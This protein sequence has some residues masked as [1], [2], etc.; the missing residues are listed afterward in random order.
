MQ[1]REVKSHDGPIYARVVRLYPEQSYGFIE[2]PGRPNVYFHRAVVEDD[3][4]DQLEVGS[5]VHVL[6]RRGGG[7]DGPAGEPRA[8]A[9]RASLRCADVARVAFLPSPNCRMVIR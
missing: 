2:T 5:E 1:R 3:A 7:A 9:A 8:A 6:A 4:F